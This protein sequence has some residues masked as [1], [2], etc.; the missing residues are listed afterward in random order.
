[1][2]KTLG[3][4]VQEKRRSPEFATRSRATSSL[5]LYRQDRRYGTRFRAASAAEN[6]RQQVA[7]GQSPGNLAQEALRQDGTFWSIGNRAS[8]LPSS[9][10]IN[11][12]RTL[13]SAASN[14]S[15]RQ[16]FIRPSSSGFCDPQDPPR[17]FDMASTVSDAMSTIAFENCGLKAANPMIRHAVLAETNTRLD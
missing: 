6:R 15:A 11:S 4:G 1:M 2:D 14:V 13:R 3:T 7:R 5:T 10:I 17:L 9:I 16:T 12:R 8:P